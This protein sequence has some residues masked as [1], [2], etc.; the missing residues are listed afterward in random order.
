MK[1]FNLWDNSISLDKELE[2]INQDKK[3]F[4]FNLKTFIIIG[5]VIYLNVAQVV[6]AWA[7]N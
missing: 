4:W 7:K 2:R 3:R 1:D 5:L 6:E